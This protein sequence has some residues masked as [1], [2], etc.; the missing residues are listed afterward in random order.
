MK[1]TI[2]D[3]TLVVELAPKFLSAYV[4]S[5][6]GFDPDCLTNNTSIPLQT[7][8]EA[9]AAFLVNTDLREIIDGG[10]DTADLKAPAGALAMTAAVLQRVASA[11]LQ[12]GNKFICFA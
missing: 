5:A 7:F 6:L 11:E 3:Q 2:A 10:F 8:G 12:K 4:L 9:C 1:T